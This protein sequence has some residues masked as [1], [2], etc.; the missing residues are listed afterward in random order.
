MG[1]FTGTGHQLD[2][3]IRDLLYDITKFQAIDFVGYSE[4][5]KSYILGEVAVRDGEL[6]IATAEDY[7]EF[8]SLRVKTTQ[9]SIRLYIQ[10][11]PERQR[12]GWLQW[13]WMADPKVLRS[14]LRD[15]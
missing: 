8:K 12:N 5:H 1:V 4:E 11:D 10:R 7:L 6:S 14:L 15:S 13:M 9:K 2:C 3:I